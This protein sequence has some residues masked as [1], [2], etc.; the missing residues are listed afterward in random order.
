MV[1][2]KHYTR[3]HNKRTNKRSVNINKKQKIRSRTLKRKQQKGGYIQLIDPEYESNPER[4]FNKITYSVEMPG[5]MLPQSNYEYF[6]RIT[7]SPNYIHEA[8]RTQPPHSCVFESFF[9]DKSNPNLEL[10]H[11]SLHGLS[12]MS[13][14]KQQQG[15]S[16]LCDIFS[17]GYP[18]SMGIGIQPNIRGGGLSR[19][20]IYILTQSILQMY[21]SVARSPSVI[22]LYIDVDASAGFWDKLGMKPE[23]GFDRELHGTFKPPGYGYEKVINFQKLINFGLGIF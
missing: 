22:N 18:V 23:K 2:K 9:V 14:R 20:L 13:S 16:Q 19:I 21:P 7:Q 15:P 11:F 12:Y 5:V 6:F 3:K 1:F 17:S 4:T 10:G 8:D